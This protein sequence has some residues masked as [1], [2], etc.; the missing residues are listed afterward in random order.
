MDDLER[1][2]R[3][4]RWARHLIRA[5]LA[6]AVAVSGF[7]AFLHVAMPNFP[8][9]GIHEPPLIEILLPWVS[10]VLLI[11]GLVWIVRLSRPDPEAGERSWRYRVFD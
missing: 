11:T 8:G 1:R 3:R 10:V 5:E 4:L 9:R 6:I 2:Q 7:A